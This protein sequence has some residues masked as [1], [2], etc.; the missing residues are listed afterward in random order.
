MGTFLT[1][2][3]LLQ[4]IRISVPYVL[5][6]LGGTVSERSGVVN[7][8]LEGML[9][10]GAFTTTVGSHYSHSAI[11]GAFCGLLG[12]LLVAA[13][14]AAIVLRF[15]ADQIVT[16]VA[17]NLLALGLTRFFLKLVFHSASSS[18]NVA[19]FTDS[20]AFSFASLTALAVLGLSWYL[21]HTPGGLRIR[22][23]GE[24]PLAAASLGVNVTR[25]R[26]KAVLTSGVLAGLGG[27]WLALENH[28]FVDRMSGGRGY[29]AIAAMIFGKWR[30]GA[31]AAACLL[32]AFADA[33]QLNLQAHATVVP[34][35]L[36]QIL[37]YALTIVTL[38]GVIGRA[39]APRA[40]GS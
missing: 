32:F 10:V 35:E 31:A 19:G 14:Y 5:A 30:P 16:G 12:G 29:I 27:A 34:R 23:V 7:L 6:A 21:T 40:L 3:F 18:P 20:G 15:K 9:L 4:I 2:A 25:T 39:R 36:I 22:S 13:L 28:G 38:A 26:L 17:I 24:H 1:L 11:V 37:P 8:A 33:L